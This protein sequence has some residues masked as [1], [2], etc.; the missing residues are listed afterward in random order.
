[1]GSTRKT[2]KAGSARKTGRVGSTRKTT[3]T[4]SISN[5]GVKK[6]RVAKKVVSSPDRNSSS[7]E[8]EED[9]PGYD[10]ATLFRLSDQ[11]A[12][13]EGPRFAVKWSD[14]EESW[15]HEV[16]LQKHNANLVYG[17]WRALDGGR[18]EVAGYDMYHVFSILGHRAA[19]QKRKTRAKKNA[20][21]IQ[22][23]G[24]DEEETS[25]EPA[26][27]VARIAPQLK[28]TYDQENGL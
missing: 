10:N 27:K 26:V 2:D 18:D 16:A 25:W 3:K 22:W 7:P 13:A 11:D 23:V 8:G 12:E 5:A 14:D 6:R 19:R 15:E 1:M 24:Y 9:L 21:E 28:E 20:Y 4:G 17:Y